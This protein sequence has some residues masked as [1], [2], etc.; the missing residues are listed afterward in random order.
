[1]T[2][3]LRHL[4][5]ISLLAGAP[6]SSVL[7]ATPAQQRAS[8]PREG[9]RQRSPLHRPATKEP[10]LVPPAPAPAGSGDQAATHAPGAAIGVP[11][12]PPSILPVGICAESLRD[13]A[14]PGSCLQASSVPELGMLMPLGPDFNL[15]L[16]GHVGIGTLQPEHALDLVGDLRGSGRLAIGNDAAIGLFG[17]YDRLFELSGRIQDFSSSQDWATYGSYITLDPQVDLTGANRTYIYSHDMIVSTAEGN[18]RDFEFIEGP[19]LLAEHA[20]SGSVAVLVGSL[21]GA[22]NRHG[23]VDDQTG[24]YV[25]SFTSEVGTVNTNKALIV[26][27]GGWAGSIG[28]NFG[29]IIEQPDS[30]ATMTNNYGLYIEDQDV[31]SNANYALYSEGGTVYLGGRVGIGTSAPGY[32]LQVGE[33]GD[34]SEA[35]ANAWNVLSSREYKRDIEPLDNC[36][37]DEILAKIQEIDVVHYRY[38]NDEHTHLGVIAEDSPAEILAKDGKGVSL[39][40]YSAFLLA[41][42]KAQQA[43]IDELRAEVA[44]LS[45]E[46]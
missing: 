32:A 41:G 26:S 34:G 18:T 3:P 22:Q 12:Q 33:A 6:A 28:D 42:M 9:M 15:D 20:G 44:R 38:V 2:Q 10:R 17:Y 35:R 46:R 4:A 13:Q 8:S 37:Y 21:I 24:V 36:G 31:A 27:S 19:Y 30:G 7:A 43:Q 25:T 11:G 40:D 16:A 45:A 14:V 5:L 1:M 39:G 23:H 29:T